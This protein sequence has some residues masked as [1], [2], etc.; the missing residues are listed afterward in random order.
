MPSHPQKAACIL[1]LLAHG[2]ASGES[3]GKY[4]L[5][6]PKGRV[7]KCLQHAFFHSTGSIRSSA[8]Q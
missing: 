1:G 3:R 6:M 8:L 5:N 4:P 7:A 2:G